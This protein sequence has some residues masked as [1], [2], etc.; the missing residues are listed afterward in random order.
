MKKF[1]EMYAKNICGAISGWD[2]IRFR[3]TI[4]WLAN[5]SGINSYLCSRNILLKNFGAWAENITKNVR[6]L[7]S[8][9]AKALDIP[10]IY[11]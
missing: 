3:G 10:M 7:C 5:T 6:S 4:R 11:L 9:Q 8:D 2:R 1:M